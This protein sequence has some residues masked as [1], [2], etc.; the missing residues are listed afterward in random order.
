M[1]ELSPNT[2]ARYLGRPPIDGKLEIDELVEFSCLTGKLLI[3]IYI[4]HTTAEEKKGFPFYCH[5]GLHLT[6]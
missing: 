4:L 3:Y 2:V 6:F 5:W 1:P